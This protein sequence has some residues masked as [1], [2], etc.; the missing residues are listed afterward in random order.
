MNLGVS[1]SNCWRGFSLDSNHTVRPDR[2]PV[3]VC[4]YIMLSSCGLKGI[5][6]EKHLDQDM[7]AKYVNMYGEE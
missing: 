7:V 4:Q 2:Y 3:Q 6:A 1:T 5:L